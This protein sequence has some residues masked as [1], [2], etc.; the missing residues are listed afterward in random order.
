MLYINSLWEICL[1]VLVDLSR[2]HTLVRFFQGLIPLTPCLYL[3]SCTLSPT[4]TLTVRWTAV[5]GK[6]SPT[7]IRTAPQASREDKR[8]WAARES[9]SGIPAEGS[10][11]TMVAR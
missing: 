1:K 3:N 9:S 4:D 7:D 11:G 6:T 10:G 5:F 2:F 8:Q